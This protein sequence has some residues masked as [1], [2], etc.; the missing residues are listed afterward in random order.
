MLSRERNKTSR[1]F[2]Y[3]LLITISAIIAFT[4]SLML[5]NDYKM[6]EY[7]SKL[8]ALKEKVQNTLLYEKDVEHIEIWDKYLT[9]A[10]SFGITKKIQKSTINFLKS[11]K[12]CKRHWNRFITRINYED[13]SMCKNH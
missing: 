4:D 13:Y 3:S 9:Y 11:I 5:K 7:Y 2:K 12:R 10:I 8:H 1:V 6:I